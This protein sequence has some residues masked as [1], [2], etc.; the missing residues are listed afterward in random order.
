MKR[1]LIIILL[2]SSLIASCEKIDIS[3]LLGG[4]E[5]EEHTEDTDNDNT[6]LPIDTSWGYNCT[7]DIATGDMIDSTTTNT[8]NATT[9]AGNGTIDKP[10]STRDFT[11]GTV[12]ERLSSKKETEI[13]NVW[14]KGYIVGYIQGRSIA[15]S[16]FSY[17]NVATNIILASNPYVVDYRFCVAIQLPSSSAHIDIRESLNVRDNPNNIGRQVMLSGSAT[18]YMSSYG[19]KNV[20]KYVFM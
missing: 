11:H 1:N 8:S 2:L 9:Q 4:K 7:F 15:N 10:Y 5:S 16:V 12:Y 19:L 3:S 17:G 13:R 20:K 6:D 18:P 14:L